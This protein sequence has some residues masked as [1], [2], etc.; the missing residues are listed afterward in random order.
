MG[1]KSQLKRSWSCVERTGRKVIYASAWR[2]NR[3]PASLI[4]TDSV[5]VALNPALPSELQPGSTQRLL[6]N[7]GLG[8]IAYTASKDGLQAI[9]LIGI[10]R[11][12]IVTGIHCFD[13]ALH[14]V[15]SD[16]C[17]CNETW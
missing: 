14:D 7:P 13:L 1:L 4:E 6:L 16:A 11:H 2:H 3:R 10:K 12:F 8:P 5:G 17:A 9:C 15:S